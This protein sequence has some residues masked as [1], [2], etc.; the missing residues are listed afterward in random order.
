LLAEGAPGLH[1]YSLNRSR[2]TQAVLARL[3]MAPTIAAH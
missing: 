3:G 2:S 1:F